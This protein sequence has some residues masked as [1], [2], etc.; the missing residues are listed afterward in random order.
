MTRGKARTTLCRIHQAG[1]L[2][3]GRQPPALTAIDLFIIA[4]AG[5]LE[6]GAKIAV[7]EP[8]SG[9]VLHAAKTHL[10]E[11]PAKDGH[12][13]EGIGAADP[14]LYWRVLDHGQ[15]LGGHLYDDAV[16]I[17]VGH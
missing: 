10:F 12:E 5:G 2:L 3:Y 1:Q 8:H 11:L 16:G 17:T 14:G 4:H 15:Y 6:V 13:P 9:K 7:N